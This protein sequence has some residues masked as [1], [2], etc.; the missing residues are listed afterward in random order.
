MIFVIDI[1]HFLDEQGDLPL[2]DVPRRRRALRLAQLVEAGGPLEVGQLRE[3]L[4]ACTARPN[5]KPCPGLLWVEKT[6][7][8]R[9]HGYCLA[10]Q[11]DELLISGWQATPWAA[12]PMEP[13]TDEDFA[14]S[15]DAN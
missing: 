14:H 4:V 7:D 11:R 1:R 3:T 5:R 15:F 12:G 13:A 10:C 6:R 9:I 8:H 2:D